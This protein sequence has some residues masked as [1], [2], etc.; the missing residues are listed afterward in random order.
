MSNPSSKI[1]VEENGIYQFDFSTAEYVIELHDSIKQLPLSDVDFIAKLGREILFIEYKNANIAD[2]VKPEAMLTKIKSGDFYQKVARKYYDSLLLF[3]AEQGQERDLPIR[4]I[5]LIE[6]P[7]IDKR[8][9][10]QLKLKI[11]K[12]LP[13]QLKNNNPSVDLITSFEVVDLNE[14]RE[15]VPVVS[16]R[17]VEEQSER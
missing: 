17:M 12:Q 3:W 11:G 10:R 15:M 1:L 6:A 5:L 8:L 13:F 16:V 4:Y 9:R 7:L 2:A 14:W